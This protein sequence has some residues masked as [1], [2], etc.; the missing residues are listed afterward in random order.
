M[1]MMITTSLKA[2]QFETKSFN[3][4]HMNLHPYFD[5]NFIIQQLLYKEQLLF[6]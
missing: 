4:I 2:N 1:L 5:M 6:D 3:N